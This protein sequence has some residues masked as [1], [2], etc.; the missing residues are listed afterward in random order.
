MLGRSSAAFTEP[1]PAYVQH[2]M[3]R[4]ACLAWSRLLASTNHH[5]PALLPRRVHRAC[6]SARPKSPSPLR[7]CRCCTTAAPALTWRPHNSTPAR[8]FTTPRPGAGAAL[9]SPLVRY[10]A[11]AVAGGWGEAQAVQALGAACN[12]APNSTPGLPHSFNPFPVQPNHGQRA[13]RGG[14]E[15]RRRLGL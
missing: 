6:P 9:C 10:T 7:A 4:L 11:A 12:K 3:A 14:Q 2:G 13:H 15:E 5:H 8:R 1:L